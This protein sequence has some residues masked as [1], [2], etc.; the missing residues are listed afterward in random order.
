MS[1][2]GEL[3]K[4]EETSTELALL[5]DASWGAGVDL[6]IDDLQIP[7]LLIMQFT[8]P[9]V[10]QPKSTVRAG[11]IVDSIDS[12]FMGDDETPVELIIFD[13]FKTFKVMTEKVGDEA[14]ERIRVERVTPENADAPLAFVENGRNLVRDKVIN[15]YCLLAGENVSASLPY[16]LSLTRTSM[17]AAKALNTMIA[18]LKA[19]NKGSASTTFLLTTKYEEGKKGTYYVASLKAGRPTT[20]E[21]LQAARSWYDDIHRGKVKARVDESDEEHESARGPF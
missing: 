6:Q 5:T 7:K 12:R 3:V 16:V 15:Y 9:Q 17:N 11:Q 10:K 19:N 21:E 14:Q 8:S 13:T 20:A 2:K 4:V 1:K 18:R